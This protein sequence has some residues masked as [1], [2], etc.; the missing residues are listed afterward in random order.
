VLKEEEEM[1][2]LVESVVAEGI[3][4]V[5]LNRPHAYNAFDADTVHRLAEILMAHTKDP[6][7]AGVVLTGAGKAFC[8]GGDLRWLAECGQEPA[9][10]FHVLVA[11]YHQAILEIRTMPKPVVAA[12]HGMAAGGG[13]SLALACDF[14]VLTQSAVMRQGYTSNGLSIDGG[15]TF[16]LPRMVG[17]AKALEIAALDRPISAEQALSLGLAT[18]VVPDGRA[19]ER[20][21]ALIREVNAR[22]LSSFGASKRLINES[23]CNPL[24]VQLERERELLARCADHPNGREGMAAFLE[25]RK[26]VFT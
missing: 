24:E 6:R 14:R 8:A 10:A 22:P 11:V 20:S 18:E 12:V 16:T 15:G 23:L 7:V 19:L 21:L 1:E 25:K 9:A 3:A 2:D 17:T 4:T 5:T 13:F 26:P